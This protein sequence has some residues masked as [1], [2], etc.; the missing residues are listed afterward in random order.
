MNNHPSPPPR[1]HHPQYGYFDSSNINSEE[2][3]RLSGFGPPPLDASAVDN[4]DEGE[5]EPRS[6]LRM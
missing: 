5:D 1:H 2:T 3:I 4:D 6:K